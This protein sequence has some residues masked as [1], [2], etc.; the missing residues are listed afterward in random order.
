MKHLLVFLTFIGIVL[1]SNA[2]QLTNEGTDFYVAFTQMYDQANAVFEINIS[3]RTNANGTVQITGTGFSQ[4]FTVA[5][6]VVTTVT[7]PSAAAN[8]NVSEVVLERAIHVTTDVPCTVYASTFHSARSEASICLPITALASDYMVTT[9]PTMLK[10]GVWYQS[11]FIVVAG[12]QACDVTIIPS[13]NTDGGVAAGTPISVH[14][15]P[16]EV[17]QVKAQTGAAND[18]TGT[19]VSA[20]NGTDKFAVFNGHVWAYLSNCGNL[21]ADPLY[22]QCY[23][24]QS[25]GK[26]YVLMLSIEQN[27]NAYRVVASQNGTTFTVDGVPTGGTLNAGDVYDGNFLSETA[28]VESN[29]PVAVTQTMTTG[30]CSGNG[31]P[32]MI[33]L[34]S[35]EQMY[36]D[37]VTFYAASG[38]SNL[39]NYVNVV[40]RSSDTSTMQFNSVPIVGWTLVPYDNTYSYKRFA[41]GAGSHTL[42]TT[43]CGF[44]AYAYGMGNPESYFYAAGARVNAVDDSI[45][46]LNI[47]TSQQGLCDL[48]SIQFT[49]FTSGGQ[50][51]VYNWDFGDGQTS[52]QQNPLHTYANPGTYTVTLIVEYLC[53]S[54]TI[55]DNVT[56]Y[57]SPVLSGTATDVTCYDWGNGSIAVNTTGGTPN[58]NYQWS[59]G[60]QTSEDLSGLD[61]GTYTLLVTDQNGCEDEITFVVNEPAPIDINLTPAGPFAP[62]DGNQQLQATPSGG[63]W[64][65]TSCPPG[66][67]TAGGSFD[68]AAAGPGLWNVC[69]TVTV[70]G[71]DSSECMNILVDT[72]CAMLAFTNEPTCYGFSDGSFT[73]NVSGGLGTINFVLTNSQGSQ[74]NAG[75]SNTANNLSTGW[76]YI[77]VTDDIC[78]FND[79]VFLD[80]PS[81]MQ[82]EM[83]ITDVLC[84][85]DLTGSAVVTNVLN[86]TGDYQDISYYWNPVP[87]GGNGVGA[88]SLGGVGAGTYTILINDENGCSETVDFTITQPSALAFAEFGSE[89]AYC[90]L[91]SYQNGNGVVFA[92]ATGGTPDYTYEW[93]DVYNFNSSNNTTWGG[94]N[95]SLYKMTVTDANG[96][97]LVGFI[98]LDSLSP[99]ADFEVTAPEFLDYPL[100]QGTADVHAHFVNQSMYFA[101]PN[102]PN[103]DTTFF[104]NFDLGAGWELSTDFYEEFD[105]I[106]SD[107]GT[108]EVCLVA[109]N[110]NGC[111]DTACKNI[112]VWDKPDLTLPNVF[113]PGGD[114]AGDGANDVFFFP[115]IAIDEFEAVIVNRWGKTIFEFTSINDVWDGSDKSGSPCPDGVYF[116]TYK[117]VATN[118]TEFEGQGNI[119]LLRQK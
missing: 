80:E 56:V 104:W 4:N 55:S 10:S 13:C 42:T 66:S 29:K 1:N 53:F 84:N 97:T 96:C 11:C 114:G 22:E 41:T 6:G 115:N 28:V 109:L 44:L 63:T 2:Q 45:S 79:S 71:C 74:V 26:E 82:L 92:S 99:V 24:L 103:A 64:T 118:G 57:N 110:K 14:L 51:I 85:G 117:A 68:P 101:N 43:G 8:I 89:P 69:Y 39:V 65:C 59:P 19:L 31:D 49:P 76:Y 70:A 75:N 88:D 20:D 113:T 34:N 32:S 61:G 15:D 3:S 21:N 60:G 25:W 48:D 40:T 81:Q 38:G 9:Y 107:S 105:S 17:Y 27:D 106:Y 91:Y 33:V 90:R 54:D 12:D 47:N 30:V 58:Y 52:S 100:L 37:T 36:L 62:P 77:N 72:S 67:V 93:F 78:T 50:V 108:Y 112:L 119:H 18:L 111:T 83:D 116:Y 35:N 98:E 7:L 87:S 23:P 5:P 73:V 16:N 46:F 86:Y 94:R 95:P 102:N